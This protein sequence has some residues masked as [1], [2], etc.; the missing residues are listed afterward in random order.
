M[1]RKNTVCFIKKI[2]RFHNKHHQQIQCKK[3]ID[4]HGTFVIVKI[5]VYDITLILTIKKVIKIHDGMRR[6]RRAGEG[7]GQGDKEEM[8]D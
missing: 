8:T 1:V 2:T 6:K 3:C 7:E 4:Y 5:N